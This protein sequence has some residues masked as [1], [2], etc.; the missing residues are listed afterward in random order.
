MGP[1]QQSRG[2]RFFFE[3]TTQALSWYLHHPMPQMNQEIPLTWRQALVP[4]NEVLGY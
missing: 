1:R 2:A 4:L 3:T